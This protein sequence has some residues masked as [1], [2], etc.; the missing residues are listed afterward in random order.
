MSE[1]DGL[2]EAVYG[3]VLESFVAL[4]QLIR[5]CDDDTQKMCVLVCALG[6]G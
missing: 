4:T 5:V 1:G 2:V 3:D 6:G